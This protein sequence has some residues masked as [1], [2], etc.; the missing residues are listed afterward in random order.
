MSERHRRGGGSREVDFT[1]F[2]PK[3]EEEGCKVMT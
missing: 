2:H 1:A 3:D